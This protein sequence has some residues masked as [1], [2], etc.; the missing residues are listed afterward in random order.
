MSQAAALPLYR[1]R[2]RHISLT[3]LIDVVFILL[4]FFMLTSSFSRWKAVEFQSP[5]GS[6]AATAATPQVLVLHADGALSLPQQPRAIA[7]I[8]AIVPDQLAALDSKQ[9]LVL[10]T[11]ADCTVQAIVSAL[12]QL[13]SAGLPVSLG[14]VIRDVASEAR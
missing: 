6:A 3:A 11:E 9:P 13:K 5:V 7:S 10:R 4:M 8:A 12:D 1:A 2:R 14:N